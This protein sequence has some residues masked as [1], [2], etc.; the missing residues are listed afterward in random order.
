MDYQKQFSSQQINV[1][2]V[3]GRNGPYFK[4]TF[5][6]QNDTDHKWGQMSYELIGR[7][8]GEIIVA[9]PG[10]TYSWVIQ[11]HSSSYL[12]ADIPVVQGIANWELVI[13]DIK[14]G[15]RI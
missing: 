3:E 15:N 10:S 8:G 5:K 13:K 11:P 2:E 4:I 9:E 6:V 7:T 12:S 14:T 1:V